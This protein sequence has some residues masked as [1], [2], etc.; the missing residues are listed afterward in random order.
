MGIRFV[1]SAEIY[2]YIMGQ[3]TVTTR[4]DR[5]SE[6]VEFEYANASSLLSW[7]YKINWKFSDEYWAYDE[8]EKAPYKKQGLPQ[9]SFEFSVPK[10][11]YGHNLY[12]VGLDRIYDALHI[13]VEAFQ[14]TF[15]VTLPSLHEMNI[16][17]VDTACNFLLPDESSVFAYCEYLKRLEYPRRQEKRNDYFGGLYWGGRNSTVKVYAKGKEFLLHDKDRLSRSEGLDNLAELMML[18][19]RIL[20]VEV[21]HK[22]LIRSRVKEYKEIHPDE[23]IVCLN[24]YPRLKDFYNIYDCYQ[25]FQNHVNRL[26]NGTEGKVV[27]SERVE[28][29]LLDRY[30]SRQ[31]K[32][33]IAIYYSWAV[34]GKSKAR[35]LC[36]KNMWSRATTAFRENNI[37]VLSSDVVK[38]PNYNL[39]FPEAF[40]LSL[41]GNPFL[42]EFRKAA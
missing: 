17:R 16:Y 12:T 39:G 2:D 10:V 7:N 32:T 34:Q 29:I 5:S 33:F 15:G 31:A 36:T 25:E 38:V 27:N 1:V 28:K 22:M 9:L 37:S 14:N 11:L 26:L 20:R 35:Q 21:E 3:S 8:K 23:I 30:G 18:S 42:Q 4:Y 24:G 6:F 19:S 13:V 40:N 41:T